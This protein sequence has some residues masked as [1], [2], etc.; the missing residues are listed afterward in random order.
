MP[1]HFK[2]IVVGGGQAGLAVGYQLRRQQLP[3]V[4]L[5]ANQRIGDSWRA[6]WDSLRLFTPARFNGLA[7][8]PFPAPANS[9]I[10]K[11]E[12][13]NYLEQYAA[14]FALPVRNG[15]RVQRLWREGDR[16]RLSAGDE[17][18]EADNVVVA[19]SDYQQPRLPTVAG[20]LSSQITQLHSSAYRNPSQLQPGDVLIVGLGNSGAEIA[21]EVARG[22]RTLVA[23]RDPGSVPFRM[24]GLPARLGLSRLVLRGVFHRLLTLDTPLGRRAHATSYK[25]ATPL[26]RVRPDDL[27]QAGVERVGRIVGVHEGLPTLEDGRALN[28]SNVIWCTGFHAGFSWIDLPIFG[29]HGP[30]HERGVVTSQPGLYF[31]GLHF[32]YAL[33]SSMVHGVSRDAERIVRAIARSARAADSAPVPRRQATRAVV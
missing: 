31:V 5:D 4:I 13:A 30:L 3:F 24:D 12:M 32:L 1:Q 29:E 21:V 7:G 9:F 16:F 18:F 8:M 22:H 27:A 26:I 2:T 6:R 10:T 28:V 23:G 14:E 33:S 19:M 25:Q 20:E 17:W 15:V 11:D